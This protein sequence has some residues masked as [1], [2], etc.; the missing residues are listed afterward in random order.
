M[1]L[2]N[3]LEVSKGIKSSGGSSV[4]GLIIG[5]VDSVILDDPKNLGTVTYT[6]LFGNSSGDNRA[7]PLNVNFKQFPVVDEIVAIISGPSFNLN[8][9]GTAQSKYY[10]PAFALWVTNHHNKFPNLIAYGNKAKKSTPTRKD[11]EQGLSIPQSKSATRPTT[12]IAEKDNILT[13]KPFLGDIIME[14]RWGSSIRFGSTSAPEVSNPW[15]KSGTVGDP[16]TIITNGHPTGSG[17]PFALLVEDIN[18]DK[19]SIWLTT[20]QEIQIQDIKDNF[21]LESFYIQPTVSQD[22]LLSIPTLP[23]SYNTTSRKQQDLKNNS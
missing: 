9:S 2:E 10:F 11:I 6:P 20:S 3:N 14:S 22:T 19:S 23:T 7:R 15:S 5:R 18:T 4:R 8:E 16:I 12:D 13:L 21:S 17:D 1:Q